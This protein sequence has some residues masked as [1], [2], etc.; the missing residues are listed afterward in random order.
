[1]D[2]CTSGTQRRGDIAIGP[3]DYLSCWETTEKFGCSIAVSEREQPLMNVVKVKFGRSK[4]S[5]WAQDQFF[6]GGTLELCNRG[7]HCSVISRN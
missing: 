5:G 3:Y 1:M 2:T 6:S 7:L 4:G